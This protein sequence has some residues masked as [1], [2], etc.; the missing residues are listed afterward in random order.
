V[1][2]G[3]SGT[4]Y[5]DLTNIQNT[6]ETNRA[7]AVEGAILTD[8][9]SGFRGATLDQVD[10][11]SQVGAF[12]TDLDIIYPGTK[13]AATVQGGEYQAARAHWLSEPNA[14]GSYTCYRPGQFTTV[15]GWNGVPAGNLHFAGEH[16]DS[17]YSFQGFMEGACLSGLRAA[18]EILADIK[19]RRR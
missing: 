1:L 3:S 11:Q 14:L 5:S 7:R 17:F 13:S 12:L 15:E 16:T 18:N 2:H 4:A 19:S 10:I 9:A 8:Y 6:W